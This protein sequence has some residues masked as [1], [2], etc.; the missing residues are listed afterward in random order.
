MEE[1]LHALV[2]GVTSVILDDETLPTWSLGSSLYYLKLARHLCEHDP[3]VVNEIKRLTTIL[4]RTYRS[5]VEHSHVVSL[6]GYTKEPIKSD[7][8]DDDEDDVCCVC[9]QKCD[10]TWQR[11]VRLRSQD[12]DLTKCGHRLHKT[13]AIR[14]IPN[15]DGTIHCPLC[16]ESIGPYVCSWIDDESNIPRF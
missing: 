9:L 16:R 10:T 13:C 8:I 11:V 15:Q 1:E 14:L 6:V 4:R 3:E 5:Y 12:G 7:H 2:Q